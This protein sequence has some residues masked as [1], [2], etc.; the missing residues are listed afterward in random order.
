MKTFTLDLEKALKEG[1]VIDREAFFEKYSNKEKKGY[2]MLKGTP[3]VRSIEGHI[4]YESEI[5]ELLP[6]KLRFL[7]GN[8][9]AKGVA[10]MYKWKR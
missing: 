2:E 1:Y 10:V 4:I 9:I 5:P 6:P 8:L 7:H 3:L